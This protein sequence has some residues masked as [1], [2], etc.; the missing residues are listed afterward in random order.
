MGSGHAEFLNSGSGLGTAE[1]K[2]ASLCLEDW[3]ASRGVN[4]DGAENRSPSLS[5][6]YT[7][8]HGPQIPLRSLNLWKGG[9]CIWPGSGVG[10]RHM[11]PSLS[12]SVY[13][14][15]VTF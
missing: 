11:L 3:V 7:V 15:L 2:G 1:F 10:V 14:F 6:T 8:A 5:P 13:P 4:G 9:R 12:S